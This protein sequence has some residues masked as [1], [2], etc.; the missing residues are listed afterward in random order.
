VDPTKKENR[1]S[2][3]RDWKVLLIGVLVGM[4]I[5]L[6]LYPIVVGVLVGDLRWDN[7]ANLI[8]TTAFYFVVVSMAS[9]LGTR[10]AIRHERKNSK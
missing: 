5:V 10:L 3:K 2:N 1:M 9:Y 8:S 4:A 7:S 6:Y